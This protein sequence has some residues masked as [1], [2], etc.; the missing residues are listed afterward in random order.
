MTC[1][2]VCV[3]VCIYTHTIQVCL[4]VLAAPW[5]AV[6][7]DDLVVRIQEGIGAAG[8]AEVAA[9]TH[10]SIGALERGGV[11]L[12]GAGGILS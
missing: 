1:V 5:T 2:C 12:E 8:N 7:V 9:D 6:A 3:H 4:P 11:V 10:G